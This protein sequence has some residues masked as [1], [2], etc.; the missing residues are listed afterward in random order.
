MGKLIR[1]T[2]LPKVKPE[3]GIPW[4]IIPNQPPLFK[5]DQ[6][7]EIQEIERKN[8]PPTGKLLPVKGGHLGKIYQT[9]PSPQRKNDRAP[10]KIWEMCGT[11]GQIRPGRGKILSD[12]FFKPYPPFKENKTKGYQG[13]YGICIA[14]AG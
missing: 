4:K 13:K 8:L 14:P 6:I 9:S 10:S 12:L 11:P 3:W 7:T 5:K 2:P 1:P